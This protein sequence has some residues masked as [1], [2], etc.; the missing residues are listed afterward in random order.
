M[1]MDRLDSQ[2]NSSRVNIDYCYIDKLCYAA[3]L[4]VHPPCKKKIFTGDEKIYLLG[5]WKNGEF[6]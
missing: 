1:L 3:H 4:D 2:M 5:I 6:V